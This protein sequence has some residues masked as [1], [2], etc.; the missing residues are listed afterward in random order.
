MTE[1]HR[2]DSLCAISRRRFLKGIGGAAA[3]F[4]VAGCL[5]K[6]AVE[7]PGS[8][9]SLAPTI[10]PTNPSTSS[11]SSKVAIAQVESYDR[12]LVRRGWK[13]IQ[14]VARCIRH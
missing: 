6:Q 10:P 2:P 7:A 14:T 12:T 9:A 5:P 4:L 11:P 8:E 1:R 13:P 3:G